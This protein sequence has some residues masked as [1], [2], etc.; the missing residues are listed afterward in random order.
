MHSLVFLPMGFL[1]VRQ[2]MDGMSE[3]SQPTGPNFRFLGGRTREHDLGVRLEGHI[4]CVKIGLCRVTGP[5]DEPIQG[6]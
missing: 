6:T 1:L 2:G 4:L 5:R 3:A